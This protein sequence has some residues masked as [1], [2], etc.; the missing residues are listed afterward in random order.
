MS[1]VSS[2]QPSS[3]LLIP[4]LDDLSKSRDCELLVFFTFVSGTLH[5]PALTNLSW[6]RSYDCSWPQMTH[7]TRVHKRMTDLS[8]PSQKQRKVPAVPDRVGNAGMTQEKRARPV[9]SRDLAPASLSHEVLT[10]KTE[11]WNFYHYLHNLPEQ[12]RV[13]GGGGGEGNQ[14]LNQG[15]ESY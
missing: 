3:R 9:W 10:E 12:Q 2:I 4:L 6:T 8:Q 11:T 15:K 7:F 13:R 14:H 1:P 5:R